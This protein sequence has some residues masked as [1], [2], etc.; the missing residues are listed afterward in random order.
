MA[1]S[2][3]RKRDCMS[4]TVSSSEQTRKS[5]AEGETKALLY[6]MNFREDSNEIYY[7]V[8][9]FFNDLTGMDRYAN[10][11][12]D[13]QSKAAKNNGPKLIGK[14]LVTLFKNYLSKFNFDY[15]ILFMGS[16]AKCVLNNVNS[17][18][19]KINDVNSSCRQKIIEGLKE[20]SKQKSYID[21]ADITDKK[22]AEFLDKVIFISDDKSPFEYIQALVSN[23]PKIAAKESV[24][25]EIFNE[26]RDLQ[27]A[28]KNKN[29]VEGETIE[30]IDQVLNYHRHIT[31]NQIRLLVLQ[32]LI[33]RDPLGKGVPE[34]FVSIYCKCP[35]EDRSD[36]LEE[37]QQSLCR[38][39][40]NNSLAENYWALFEKIYQLILSN[41]ND[42]I[43]QIYDG[44]ELSVKNGCS[45]LD[46]HSLKY[47][48]AII[49]DVLK[50]DN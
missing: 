16:V 8:V 34:H 31:S 2:I 6:L 4:Y 30:R 45:D 22:I 1:Q 41:P 42:D 35:P 12:W 25:N 15:Y 18:E 9:D 3:K 46:V 13:V 28:K 36:F 14:E 50:N 23:Y 5:C 11:L 27:S 21:N 10:K 32:R 37:C 7:F 24:C 44:I 38:A 29:S 26:L 17:Y 39:L 33:N 19:F 48:I 49:K 20:E 47:F 43:E 40:F